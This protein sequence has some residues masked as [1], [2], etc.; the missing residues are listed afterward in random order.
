M[1]L[2]F[3]A[4]QQSVKKKIRNKKKFRNRYQRCPYMI[5]MKMS[6]LV[7][8]E[9]IGII[10]NIILLVDKLTVIMATSTIL[11]MLLLLQAKL[12]VITSPVFIGRH[13]IHNVIEL[14]IIN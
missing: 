7:V 14:L 13:N 1:V 6:I 8:L 5:V 9:K 10:G 11:M 12:A 4:L 3:Y 2:L